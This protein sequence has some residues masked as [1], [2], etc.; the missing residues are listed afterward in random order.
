MIPW[1]WALAVLFGIAG[2]AV[3]SRR[4]DLTPFQDIPG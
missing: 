2:L 3:I 4:E 1:F